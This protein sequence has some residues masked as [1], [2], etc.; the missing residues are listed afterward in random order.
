ML[1]IISHYRQVGKCVEMKRVEFIS[2]IITL[3]LLHG[4]VNRSF[5]KCIYIMLKKILII[6]I[7]INNI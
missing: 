5:N 4:M 3:K 1:R 2:W 7:F 6:N